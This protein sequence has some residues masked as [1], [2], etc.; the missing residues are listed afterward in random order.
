MPLPELHIWGIPG[1]PEVRRGDDLGTLLTEALRKAGLA[2]QAGDILVVTQKVVSKAEG[3]VAD[4]TTVKPGYLALQWA[5]QY[6]KDPR[7]IE[8]VL[9]ESKRIVKMDRGVIIAETRHGFVCANAGVDVSNVGE[10]DTAILMP[11]DPDAS[12]RRLRDAFLKTYRVPLGVIITDTFGRPWRQGLT[13]VAI[14]VA[15]L[16]PLLDYRGQVDS[17]G[18]PL[19]ATILAIADELASAAEL[20]MGKVDRTAAALIR[21]YPLAEGDGSA[22]EL[23]RDPSL[24]LFR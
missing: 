17:A 4:L 7:V 16:R 11:L 18:R 22:K 15:G 14:G 21:G 1:L 13:N 24:D 19:Q 8:V 12:A 2:V 3:Q 6:G 5:Q 9:Q 10:P 23:V 20:V